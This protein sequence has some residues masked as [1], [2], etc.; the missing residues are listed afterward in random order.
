MKIFWKCYFFDSCHPEISVQRVDSTGG[1]SITGYK[2]TKY[3]YSSD[4]SGNA[5]RT[6]YDMTGIKLIFETEGAG[7]KITA[8][9]I[10]LQI[11][12]LFA[13]LL[14]PRLIADFILIYLLRYEDYAGY[15]YENTLNNKANDGD[16]E[17]ESEKELK[18]EPKK[19][20]NLDDEAEEE[21]EKKDE[22]EDISLL[23]DIDS[24]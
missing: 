17:K 2:T 3:S 11:A 15:K 8:E 22:S 23:K 24:N 20:P 14:V 21:E 19:K 13:L 6:V 5:E 7:Y 9:N 4:N 12:N 18:P 10:I 16:D 1:S